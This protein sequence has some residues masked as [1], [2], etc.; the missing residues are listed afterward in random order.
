ME[1]NIQEFWNE[2]KEKHGEEAKH[3]AVIFFDEN[4]K[5]LNELFKLINWLENSDPSNDHA[6]ADFFFLMSLIGFI[7][8]ELKL[9]PGRRKHN[10]DM[11]QVA[12]ELP[13]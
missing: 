12:D 9:I 6:N 1:K 11:R 5:W 8:K 2:V 13:F 10:A 7:G 3:G 4:Q